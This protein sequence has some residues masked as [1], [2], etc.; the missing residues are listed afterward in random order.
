MVSAKPANKAYKWV[1]ALIVI[2]I[3]YFA[4][5]WVLLYTSLEYKDRLP[6]AFILI[7]S[8]VLVI[9]AIEARL[10]Y[11]LRQLIVTPKFVTGHV[12]ALYI[13]F[14]FTPILRILT[15]VILPWY[16][17][18]AESPEFAITI[19]YLS[20]YLFWGSI[21]I[22][23]LFFIATIVKSFSYRKSLKKDANS[24][25]NLLDNIAE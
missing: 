9:L 3:I 1:V 10:Y 15:L 6:P 17:P 12:I 8:L 2:M 11:R 13:A 23:H 18:G 19:S 21:I 5:T 24:S 4:A 22:G 16:Y 14:L 25:A 20:T 7:V